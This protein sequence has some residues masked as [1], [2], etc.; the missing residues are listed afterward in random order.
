MK[1]QLRQTRLAFS[2]AGGQSGRRSL[3][4]GRNGHDALNGGAGDD[5]LIGGAGDDQ[6]TG[7]TGNDFYVCANAF[8]HD[9]ITDFVAGTA[10]A[11]DTL[12]LRGLGFTSFQDV[13]DHTDL[14]LN[15]VI[16]AGASD[17]T[18]QGVAKVQ[19]QSWDVLF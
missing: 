15:A 19:I 16:H 12:D 17:I 9:R 7:G 1:C 8:G 10:L 11:H 3:L 18:L 5:M 13:L 2:I 14:G 4:A 6:L